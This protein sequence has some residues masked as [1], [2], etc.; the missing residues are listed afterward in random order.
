MSDSRIFSDVTVDAL[1]RIKELGRAEYGVIFDPPDSPRSNATSQTPF[2]ECVIAFVHDSARA[3]LTLTI[4]KSPGSFRQVYFGAAFW[5]RSGAAA[6][7]ATARPRVG[8][9]LSGGAVRERDG[10]G[11]KAAPALP[12]R[13]RRS[14]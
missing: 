7:N 11:G 4:V 9:L 12:D 2:G 6:N 8:A 3:E 10:V 13:C 1:S 14:T 5:R